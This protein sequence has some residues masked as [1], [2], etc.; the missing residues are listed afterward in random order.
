MFFL[1]AYVC[2]LLKKKYTFQ[3]EIRVQCTKIGTFPHKHSFYSVAKKDNTIFLSMIIRFGSHVSL[4]FLIVTTQWGRRLE[5]WPNTAAAWQAGGEWPGRCAFVCDGR[6]VKPAFSVPLRLPLQW[7]QLWAVGVSSCCYRVIVHN[8]PS[9]ATSRKE[10][11]AWYSTRP[12]PFLW[13]QHLVPC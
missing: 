4:S 1:V 12:M 8:H 9:W 13:P 3:V 2:F 7:L 10:G 5:G 11:M 6:V